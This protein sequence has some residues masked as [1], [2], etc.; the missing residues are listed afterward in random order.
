MLRHSVFVASLIFCAPVMADSLD[1]NLN[2]NA[3]QFQ[4]IAPVGYSE[5]GKAELHAGFL[6]DNDNNVLGDTGL[7]VM[8][9][10]GKSSGTSLGV[11]LKAVAALS[12][13]FSVALALGGK[14]RFTPPVNRRIGLVGLVYVA[15][16]IVSFGGADFFVHGGIS[17]EYEIIKHAVAYIGYRNIRFGVENRPDMLNEKNG[18]LG[19]RITF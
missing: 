14:I 11:G 6:Y 1:V 7:L 17:V 8:S 2:N 15:P 3:A 16:K 12:G 5:E 19:V 10:M 9:D 13:D 4:Y 18:H